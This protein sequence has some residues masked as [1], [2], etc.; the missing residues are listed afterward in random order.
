MWV[1]YGTKVEHVWSGLIQKYRD[2]GI[3]KNVMFG[4]GLVREAH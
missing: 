4:S 2:Y 1:V 3:I